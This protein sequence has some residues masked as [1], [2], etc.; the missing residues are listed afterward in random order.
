MPLLGGREAVEAVCVQRAAAARQVRLLFLVVWLPVLA[1]LAW[2]VLGS[3]L[4]SLPLRAGVLAVFGIG[5][6]VAALL[7]TRRASGPLV[8]A[9]ID[10]VGVARATG[11]GVGPAAVTLACT[12]DAGALVAVRLELAS[13]VTVEPGDWTLLVPGRSGSMSPLRVPAGTGAR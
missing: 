2:R 7:S 10:S 5:V 12:S 3:G 6:G 8:L 11:E 13:G 4:G 1:L 9:R